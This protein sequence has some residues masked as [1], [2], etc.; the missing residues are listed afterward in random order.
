MKKN[1]KI[2]YIFRIYKAGYLF[3]YTSSWGNLKFEYQKKI[4]II[5]NLKKIKKIYKNFFIKEISKKSGFIINTNSS[6][7]K[8]QARKKNKND[9]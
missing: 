1:D 7:F 2:D 4:F 9:L 8:V 5:T 3:P 6:T